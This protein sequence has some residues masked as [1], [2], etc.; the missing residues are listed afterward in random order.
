MT[1]SSPGPFPATTDLS[2]RHPQVQIAAPVFRDFGGRVAFAGPA[3]TVR[4]FEDN[5][6][7][8]AALETPG[9]GRVLVVDGGASLNCALL[10]DVLGTLAV[11]NGWAGVVVNGCVRDSVALTSLPLG[12]KALATHPRRSGKGDSGEQDISLMFAGVSIE[13]GNWIYADADGLLVSSEALSLP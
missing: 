13:P 7:V 11:R 12:V 6:P 4:V 1:A 3:F 10:G 8:R 9:Q 2:D 5:T